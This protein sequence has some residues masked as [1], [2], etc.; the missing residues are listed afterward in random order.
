MEAATP[1][2]ETNS[3]HRVLPEGLLLDRRPPAPVPPAP[4]AP[5]L[6]VA[7]VGRYKWLILAL[8]VLLMAG[9]LAIAFKR[10]PEWT[11]GA[12][13]QVGR[14]NPNSP[15]FYGF[16]Q[17]ATDLAMTL[18]RHV[19]ATG[20]VNAIHKK[21]GLTT[22]QILKH[23]T[24]TPIPEGAAFQVI[25][26]ASSGPAAIQ[27]AN[28]AAAAMVRYEGTGTFVTG[29]ATAVY[30][31]YR[32]QALQFEQARAQVQNLTNAARIRNPT[33]PNPSNPAIVSAQAR[34]DALKARTSALS[35]AYTQALE[36]EPVVSSLI[37]PLSSALSATSDRR[38][39]IELFGIIGLAAGLLIGSAA[40]ILLEQR[41]VRRT[42][43]R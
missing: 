11:A 6:I 10:K 24:A 19:Q 3:G 4:P 16:V 23:V 21:T 22:E 1:T 7:A 39:K 26:T 9:G 12:T 14:I 34:A 5:S 2:H 25:A 20:V 35:A 37:S 30:N 41:R 8:T 18:S 29:T 43:G 38:H 36:S 13:L 33:T 31:L 28:T 42:Y 32:A 15:S 27:L 17:S 40:A